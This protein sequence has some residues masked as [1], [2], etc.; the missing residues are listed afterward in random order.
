VPRPKTK[1]YRLIT[2]SIDEDVL[3]YLD[4]IR[5][6]MSRTEFIEQ[7]I[8]R[9]SQDKAEIIREVEHLKKRVE[10]LERENQRLKKML[11]SKASSGSGI[12]SDEAS[13]KLLEEVTKRYKD[14]LKT[15]DILGQKGKILS[16]YDVINKSDDLIA[17]YGEDKVKNAI[18]ALMKSIGLNKYAERIE[19]IW[20]RK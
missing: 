8:T 16:I 3:E 18:K 5:E 17:E 20:Q 1:H 13:R 2:I 15:W 9:V 11:S 4:Q 12:F 7:L 14:A 6:D 10:E 19:E